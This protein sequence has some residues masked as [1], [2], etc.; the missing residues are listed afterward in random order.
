VWCGSVVAV[1]VIQ[2]KQP[3]ALTFPN[4]HKAHS[5]QVSSEQQLNLRSHPLDDTSS[6]AATPAAIEIDSQAAQVALELAQHEYESWLNANLRHPNI[7]QLFT[8]FTIGLEERAPSVPASLL[9]SGSGRFGD[10]DGERGALPLL[11]E[12]GRSA[13]LSWKTHL[14][15]EYCELGTMQV[16]EVNCRRAHTCWLLACWRCV[17]LT[18]SPTLLVYRSIDTGSVRL[19][20]SPASIARWFWFVLD[21]R[22]CI[23]KRPLLHHLRCCYRTCCSVV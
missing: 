7:V 4:R 8:S 14:V 21:V 2:V 16:W 9:F 13:S 17:G 5:Q 10:D 6:A 23:P 12:A 11:S 1:K 22:C 3:S 20:S 15:M 18:E 19:A